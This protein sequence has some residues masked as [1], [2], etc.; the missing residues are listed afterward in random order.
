M[1]TLF[2]AIC[3]L[4]GSE[5]QAQDEWIGGIGECPG[6]HKDITIEKPNDKPSHKSLRI[7]GIP[8]KKFT[9]TISSIKLPTGDAIK[10]T[11]NACNENPRGLTPI[12]EIRAYLISALIISATYIIRMVHYFVDEKN[13]LSDSDIE[14]VFFIAAIIILLSVLSLFTTKTYEIA[15]QVW[16]YIITLVCFTLY[17]CFAFIFVG[18]LLNII[19]RTQLH[20]LII[21]LVETLLT[22]FLIL[23]Y[24]GNSTADDK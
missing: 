7:P 10:Q 21:I 22:A 18:W 12:I 24:L 4:C 6:C 5:F 19:T 11:R 23:K 8:V 16:C 3:P 1:A 14:F 9:R 2:I 13:D 17:H 20:Y 15:I